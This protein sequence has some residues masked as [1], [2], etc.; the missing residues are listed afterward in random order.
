MTDPIRLGTRASTLARTQSATVGDALAEVSG[1][2]WVE[3]LVTTPGDDTT[4]PLDQPGTP[5]LFV[6]TLR[7][8]LLSGDVDVIVHSFKDL[9]SAPEPGLLL[10]AV[11]TRADPRD[12]LVSR[13]GLGL[14]QLE[15]GSVIG[16]SSPRRAAALR[17]LRP[18][19]HV[20]PIRGNV[21][22]RIRKV[23]D[24]EVDATI[25]AVAGMARI[26]RADEITE[27]LD[28]LL[29]APAQGALAVEC[30]AGDTA[31]AMLLS[32]LD[33]PLARVLTAAERQV[34][35]GINA[36]CTTAV[37]AGATWHNDTLVL[38]AELT[39]D[40]TWSSTR[41]EASCPLGN[42][43]IARTVGQ[44]AAA[45]LV[46]PD[47][48]PVLL[49]RSEGNSTDADALRALGIPS[50]SDP[51]IRISP[52]VDD[53]AAADLLSALQRAAAGDEAVRTWLI[54]T[55]PMAVPSWLA[56]LPGEDLTRL[57]RAA[58]SA[59]VRTA[60][61]GERTA[62]T[63]RDIGFESVLVPSEDASAAGVLAALE[64]EP[65]GRA[66]LPR[67]NLALPTLP[68]GLRE[69]GWRVDEAVVYDTVA[70]PDRPG[71][72]DLV[73]NGEVAAVVLRSPS[74]VAALIAHARVPD[75][76]AVVCSGT[77][78]ADAAREA[79]LRVTA[80]SRTPTPSGLAEAVA[81][82]LGG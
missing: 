37:A 79:G 5:G 16:T 23:R 78:T 42:T 36:E 80:V 14:S 28:D 65:T 34:L 38:R 69:R 60:A 46:A 55:S 58:E 47:R 50:I 26:G 56:S 59:G 21:D 73:E 57:A 24:G 52:R 9:P 29:P 7:K 77:T 35:V 70:V 67:G 72:A 17:R 54:A 49:V 63:L 62:G 81:A 39:V 64:S 76:V 53:P 25:L 82:A 40:G 20:V 44:R 27:I 66:L 15:P 48:R 22:T 31:M 41:I 33:D 71:S 68:N 75:G 45:H 32:R 11:P 13:S 3:V 43:A 1:R 18:D 2:P 61:T 10:A 74:A 6:S 51:F 4:K 30:R 8:A 12:A 19:L